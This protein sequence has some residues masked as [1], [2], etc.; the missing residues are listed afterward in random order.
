MAGPGAQRL[1]L[2]LDRNA[3]LSA[4]CEVQRKRIDELERR[5]GQGGRGRRG[6]ALHAPAPLPGPLPGSRSTRRVQGAQGS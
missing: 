3:K 6:G 5:C 1:D 2:L 4:Q